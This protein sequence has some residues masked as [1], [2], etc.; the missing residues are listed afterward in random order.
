MNKRQTPRTLLAV[1]GLLAV[2]AVPAGAAGF[3]KW[4]DEKGVT[5]YG[6]KPPEGIQAASV[7][8]RDTTSSDAEGE[9]RKLGERRTASSAEKAKAEEG[10]SDAQAKALPADEK[11]RM[12]KLCEQHRKNLATLKSGQRVVTKDAQGNKKYVSDEEKAKQL[13]FA[14][15]E[16]QRCSQ[17]E[18]LAPAGTPAR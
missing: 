1:A 6:E 17:F 2:L 18:A 9:I 13:Q 5:H 3:Y 12:R 11:E 10:K 14:E 7:K 16:V 8:V 15:G 4:V